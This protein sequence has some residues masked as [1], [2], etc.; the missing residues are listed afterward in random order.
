MIMR[1][2]RPWFLHAIVV[3]EGA[4]RGWH[5]GQSGKPNAAVLLH[6]SRRHVYTGQVARAEGVGTS[7]QLL[8]VPRK[9]ANP[10][11]RTTV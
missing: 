10:K 1:M 6:E 9:G 2:C 7:V 11:P 5:R 4:S 3:V 8:F